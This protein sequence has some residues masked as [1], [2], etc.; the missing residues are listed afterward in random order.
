MTKVI[1]LRQKKGKTSQRTDFVVKKSVTSPTQ[2]QPPRIVWEAPSFYFNPQKRY[3]SMVIIALVFAGGSMLLFSGDMLMAIFL[4][5][6][7]LVL[8]LYSTKRPEISKIMIDPRGVTIGDAVHHYKDIRSFWL[9]YDPGNL[10][11]LSL[12]LKKWYM[13][14]VKV[15]IEDKNPLIIRSILVNFLPEK[16]HEHSLVDIIARKIGL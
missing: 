7:S 11:E 3:L 14:Y 2:N 8:I 16:E 4:L 12:E 5:L 1:D 6:S 10:K 15:S 13:P 9:N